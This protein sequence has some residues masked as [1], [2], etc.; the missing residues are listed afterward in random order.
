MAQRMVIILMLLDTNEFES[1]HVY[2]LPTIPFHD[3]LPNFSF[4]YKPDSEHVEVLD[5]SAK[6]PKVETQQ[7]TDVEQMPEELDIAESGER[8]EKGE[9]EFRGFEVRYS[10]PTKRVFS[11]CARL[12]KNRI[13]LFGMS[14]MTQ[15][16]QLMNTGGRS[17]TEVF[18]D[19]WIFDVK[20]NEWV[21][22]L[23]RAD[24]TLP[25]PRAGHSFEA[26]SVFALL[27]FLRL[28]YTYG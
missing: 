24:T 11:S 23:P 17:S 2:S 19:V 1:I 7:S 10:H 21:M 22:A 26:L 15:S 20:K 16:S 12:D 9:K 5:M 13:I 18:N 8:T 3:Q 6:Y 25:K 14:S 28:Q 27:F 4:V